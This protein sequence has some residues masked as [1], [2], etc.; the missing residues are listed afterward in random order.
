MD[1]IKQH[2]D[3]LANPTLNIEAAGLLT[4]TH[5]SHRRVVTSQLLSKSMADSYCMI[6]VLLGVASKCSLLFLNCTGELLISF[7]KKSSITP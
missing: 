6:R 5:L 1:F 7:E 3:G 4:L 2:E